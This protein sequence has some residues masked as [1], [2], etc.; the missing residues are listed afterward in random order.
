MRMGQA[1]MPQMAP[2]LTTSG[3]P[4]PIAVASQ[5]VVPVLAP[6]PPPPPPPGGQ[7]IEMA[8]TAPLKLEEEA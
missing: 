5:H 4:A 8:S 7:K 6:P 1:P 2:P 3:L